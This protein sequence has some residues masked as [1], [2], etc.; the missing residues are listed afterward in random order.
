MMRRTG[1]REQGIGNSRKEPNHRSRG[2]NGRSR[3]GG[4]PASCAWTPAFAGITRAGQPPSFLRRG[5]RDGVLWLVFLLAALLLCGSPVRAQVAT[6]LPPYG[7]FSG[8]PDVVDNAN[9]NVHLEIPV[10]SKAG[11]GLPFYYILTYDN[12]LWYP[13]SASGTNTWTPVADWGWGTISQPEAGA[14]GYSWSQGTCHDLLGNLYNYDIYSSWVY[15]DSLA[16]PHAAPAT[17][18]VS[19]WSSINTNGNGTCKP[20]G[21]ASQGQAL[22]ID[23]SGYTLSVTAAP[24]A[25]AYTRSGTALQVAVG[26]QS[27]SAKDANGNQITYNGSSF[28]DTLSTTA[29][30]VSGIAPNPT[31]FTYTGPNGGSSYYTMNYTTETVETNFGCSGI[32]DYGRSSKVTAYLVTS[33]A[34]PDG[35]SYQ[36]TYEPTLN[37]VHSG[38]VTGR[39]ASVTL[40]TGGVISYTYSPSGATNNDI[41]CAD[42]SAAMLNR[43]TPD[44]GSNPWQYAHSESGTAWTTTLTDPQSNVTTF[45]FQGIYET[46]RQVAG[47]ET[48]YTCYNGASFPCNSTS[49]ALPITQRTVTASIGGLESQVNMDYNSYGLVT[50]VDEYGYGSGAVGSLV[51]KTLTT[52]TSCGVTNANVVNRPCSVTVDNPSGT[53]VASTTYSYDANGNLLTESR[54]TGGTPSALTR[55]FTYGS[56]GVLATATDFNSNTTTYSNFTCASNTAFPQTI[57]SGGLATQEAWNCAGGV[58]TSATDANSETTSYSYDTT[59]NIWRLAGISFP[60][61]GSTSI[62][63]TSATQHDSYTAVTSSLSRHDQL[64]LDGLGRVITSSLVNDPDGQ[65][66]VATSYDSEGRPSTVSNPYRTSSTGGDTYTYDALNRVTKV[67]HADSSYSQT[68]YGG[69]ASQTCSASTYGYS[70]PSLHTDESGNQRQTFTD[71]LGRV[72]EVDEPNSSGSLT[73]NTCYAYDVLNNLYQVIQGSETRTF[74]HDMLSRLTSSTTPEAGTV[75]VYYSTSAGALCSGRP[76]ALCRRTDARGVTTTYT[77]DSLNRRTGKSYSNGNPTA[78]AYTYDQTSCLG[79]SACYNKGRRTTMTDASG[80]TQW[81]Y[82]AMGRILIEHRTIGSVTN[83]I[84]YTYNLDGST[85]TLTYPSGRTITYTVSAAQRPLSAVDTTN[86]INYALDATYAPQGAPAGALLGESGS[87]GGIT[88]AATYTNRLQPY[89]ATASSSAGNALNLT[90][91]Y[92]ANGNVE[93]ATNNLNTARTQT[94]TY[95]NLNRLSTAQSQ[96]TSGTYCWGQ[97]FGYDRY[98]NLL[99]STVTQ[100]TAPMLSL[101]VSANNQ[102]TNSGFTYDASGDLTSDGTYT[103]AWDARPR[104]QSAA[105][106]TYTYDGDGKRVMK[107]SGTLYWN[108]VHGAP[109][110]ETN[111]SGST[112]NEYI[113]FAGRR[114]ARRDSSGNV[115]YYFS[116]RLGTSKTITTSAGVVCTMPISS[117]SATRWHTSL[118]APRITSSRGLSA[119]A[120][121]AWTTLGT[122]NTSHSSAVG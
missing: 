111:A 21:P 52:Y 70:Y 59:N 98:G 19:D 118:P 24:A 67:T 39:L 3:A 83:N 119:T 109:L 18:K 95:D 69:S 37:P 105:G 100:C 120:R 106:V 54:S 94:F 89:T 101:N 82:D 103:Y 63:Y 44:T 66:Y 58:L 84:D 36:F 90:F 104:L 33:I 79:L 68:S 31:T 110:A 62:T 30:T 55:T 6:G 114:I 57:T 28:T 76:G 73:V 50:E 1:N 74:A 48:I 17:L 78:T 23:G 71:A 88:Y 13:S 10:L 35:T 29:L 121:R 15:Y 92:Y 81:A 108:R 40:P 65:T 46:E 43:S 8:G 115:Y 107:S 51:R 14:A 7:S 25:T 9:L 86:N 102:I 122:A 38:A 91:G 27:A 87:F 96:A 112:L 12:S 117:P 42:G 20:I 4:D 61:G 72:I 22:L 47:L 80:S 97:S 49:V 41:V 99:S 26:S 16:A 56:Y 2:G 64:D 5:P 34:L 32:S 45:S 85:K 53:A 113:F 75:N 11:R 116:D 60:D 93:T 77:Y